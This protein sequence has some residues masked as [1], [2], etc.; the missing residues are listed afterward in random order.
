MGFIETVAPRAL[1]VSVGEI[2]RRERSKTGMSQ[3]DIANRL[4]VGIQS[5]GR[6]ERGL[7][8]MSACELLDMLWHLDAPQSVFLEILAED[9]KLRER[10]A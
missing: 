7:G 3:G 9:A 4:G 2:V 10:R 1:A 8:S 6:W 5:V